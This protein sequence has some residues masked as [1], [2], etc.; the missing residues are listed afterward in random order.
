LFEGKEVPDQLYVDLFIAKL[1][2]TY[3]IK[4]RPTLRK[5]LMD[6]ARREMEL[7]KVL[8][9]LGSEIAELKFA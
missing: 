6:D 4:D 9:E 7:T 2:L 8:A 5:K 1:R 3:E